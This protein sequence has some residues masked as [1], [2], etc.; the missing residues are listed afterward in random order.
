MALTPALVE[1]PFPLFLLP[2]TTS[3]ILLGTKH[4]PMFPLSLV[5]ERVFRVIS[6]LP[7]VRVSALNVEDLKPP[8]EVTQLHV[9]ELARRVEVLKLMVMEVL[10][11][12]DLG[13]APRA[14]VRELRFTVMEQPLSVPALPL[15]VMDRA[16]E[17]APVQLT[18]R[19]PRFEVES[20][21]FTVRDRPFRVAAFMLKVTEV[22]LAVLLPQQPVSAPLVIGATPPLLLLIQVAPTSRKRWFVRLS[23]L[24]AV[25]WL[26]IQ[27]F[28]A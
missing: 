18:V 21:M 10:P 6:L 14:F 25:V 20:P 26:A 9:V 5:I 11:L 13:P 15:I 17:V 7:P 8:V 24:L 16:L 1:A 2:T 27:P 3:P 4:F 12:A 22:E 19:E 23:R 28:G